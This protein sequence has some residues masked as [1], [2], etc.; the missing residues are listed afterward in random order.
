M[1]EVDDDAV[2]RSRIAVDTYS[3]ALSEPGDIVIPLEAGIITREQIIA[4]LAE[5]ARGERVGRTRDDEITL[6]KSVGTA[7]ADL[8]A[9]QAVLSSDG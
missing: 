6:F 3:G 8:A 4:D 1:R 2:A 5:L 7:L 9:A